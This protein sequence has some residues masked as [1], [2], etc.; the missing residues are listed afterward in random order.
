VRTGIDL[1]TLVEV[2]RWL[3]GVLGRRLEG[4]LHRAARW[5]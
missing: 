4:Y 5:P 3:E 1:E 2:S